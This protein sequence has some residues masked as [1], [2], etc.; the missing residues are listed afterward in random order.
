VLAALVGSAERVMVF[1]PLRKT[2][3]SMLFVLGSTV[4]A[5]LLPLWF[6]PRAGR[7]RR[8]L[9]CWLVPIAPVIFWWDGLVTCTRLWT[10]REWQEALAQLNLRLGG[11]VRSSL[12]CQMV[13]V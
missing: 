7:L 6:L 13:E 11:T 10:N 1:E 12:F 5:L 9:W 3:L 2:L 4:P 8:F